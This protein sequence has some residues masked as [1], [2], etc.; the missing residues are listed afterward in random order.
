MMM[1]KANKDSEAGVMPTKELIDAMGKYNQQLIDA[2]VLLSLDGLQSSAKGFRVRFESDNKTTIVNGPFGD[3]SQLVAGYWIIKVNSREEAME[4]ARR[5]PFAPGDE[6][7]VRQ[8]FE[9]DDFAE[10]TL[11]PEIRN[12]EQALRDREVPI[13]SNQ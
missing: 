11:S 8:I 10:E 1:I 9:L 5:A 7:E 6:I 13:G 2:G 12:Q 3:P 4:W